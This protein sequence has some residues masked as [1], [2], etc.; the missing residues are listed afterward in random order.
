MEG[1][2]PNFNF[3]AD[4]T[5]AD[6]VYL[7][8]KPLKGISVY[9]PSEIPEHLN[10]GKNPRVGDV[11]VF[12]DSAWSITF[13]K[14]KKQFTGGT[15]GYDIRNTD[16]HTIFYAAGPAFKQN[17]IH[18][19]FQNIHIYPLLALLLGIMPAKT[20]GDLL[21]VVDMLKPQP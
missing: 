1:G 12:A 13:N 19:S 8:L 18:P 14:P 2:N 7:A 16:V 3:Y 21:Q 11:I 10:Y 6:S 15:H 9:R 17:Y 5:Y 4:G 20:D